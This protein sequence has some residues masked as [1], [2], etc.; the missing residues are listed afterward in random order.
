MKHSIFQK[1]KTRLFWEVH[2]S[3]KYIQTSEAY[4][5]IERSESSFLGAHIQITVFGT[6]RIYWKFECQPFRWS[7]KLF[8]KNLFRRQFTAYQDIYMKKL[9]KTVWF[10]RVSKEQSMQMRKIKLIL[11]NI[12]EKDKVFLLNI[13]RWSLWK[14]ALNLLFI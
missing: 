12:E 1:L 8:W 14:L 3:S 10:D 9:F 5:W 2:F 13:F 11:K 7:F 4:L 6:L